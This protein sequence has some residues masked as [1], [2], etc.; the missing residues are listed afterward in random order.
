[1]TENTH[2][3]PPIGQEI[4]CVLTR[5]DNLFNLNSPGF[6]A[7]LK[8]FLELEKFGIL[9]PRALFFP[10]SNQY[11]SFST[12]SESD[13]L[14]RTLPNG[15]Y[16]RMYSCR[17]PSDCNNT[18]DFVKSK[19]GRGEL[20]YNNFQVPV[21]DSE[22]LLDLSSKWPVSNYDPEMPLGGEFSCVMNQVNPLAFKDISWLADLISY[23]LAQEKTLDMIVASSKFEP[24]GHTLISANQ[25]HQMAAHT[26]DEYDSVYLNVGNILYSQKCI[27]PMNRARELLS[28]KKI[29]Y[30]KKSP[31]SFP[32]L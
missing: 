13:F 26:Y 2:V 31:I 29:L 21:K 3:S 8:R 6:D 25:T 10:E 14:Y 1:M 32:P 11:L 30:L 15:A 18:L 16:F 7:E 27:G 9:N 28:P 5:K 12:L 20:K 23:S 19:L 24:Q 4:S 22:E 17:S